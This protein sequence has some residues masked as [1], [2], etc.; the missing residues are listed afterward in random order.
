MKLPGG[1]ILQE[2]N[3]QYTPAQTFVQSID[4]L[5]TLDIALY[6]AQGAAVIR[7]RRELYRLSMCYIPE[8]MPYTLLRIPCLFA[9]IVLS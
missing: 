2:K 8:T 4:V 6:L 5:F 7:R 1:E 9:G 3:D